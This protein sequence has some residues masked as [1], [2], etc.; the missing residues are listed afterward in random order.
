LFGKVWLVKNTGTCTWT[1]DYKLVNTNGELM[2]SPIELP[3]HQIVAPGETIELR[4][5]FRAP[6]EPATYFNEWMLQD[7]YGNRFGL[8]NSGEEPLRVQIIVVAPHIP[9]PL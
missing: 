1:P 6:L 4:I 8:G 2:G 9:N 5:T 3:I 7:M